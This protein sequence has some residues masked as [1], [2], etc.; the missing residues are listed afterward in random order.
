M[1]YPL[2]IALALVACSSDPSKLVTTATTFVSEADPILRQAYEDAQTFC[3]ASGTP[4]DHAACVAK[5][6]AAWEPI[7]KGLTDVRAAWC[8]VE[9]AKCP[10]D[11]G[12]E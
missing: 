5:V 10:S 6:R 3:F 2:A 12:A 11:A 9:P 7:I 4:A 1:K 8:E